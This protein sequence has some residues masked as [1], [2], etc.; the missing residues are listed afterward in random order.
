MYIILLLLLLSIGAG[1]LLRKVR[2]VQKVEHGSRYTIFALL[3][4]FG[5]SI[6]SNK[7]LLENI[8]QLGGRAVVIALL[9]VAGSLV[10]ACLFQRIWK[11]GKG[12]AE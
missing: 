2:F 3:F 5:I 7:A 11:E 8:M 4:V 10:A 6:G 9:G 1:H 12:G